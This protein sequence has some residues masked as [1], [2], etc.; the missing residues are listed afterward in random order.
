MVISIWNYERCKIESLKYSTRYE[1]QTNSRTAY[2]N[3]LKNKWLDKICKHMVNGHMQYSFEFCKK[4]V[5]KYKTRKELEMK[6]KGCYQAC[7]R[8]NWLDEIA[9]HMPKQLDYSFIDC[10]K[11][12][13]KYK[14]RRE[15]QNN[16]GSHYKKAARK[17]WLNKICKHM[18]V[19]ANQVRREKILQ[20][21]IYKELYKAYSQYKITT[22]YKIYL[23]EKGKKKLLGSLDFYIINPKNK[24]F[25][26]FELKHS[27]STW[28]KNKIKKQLNK[29]EEHFKDDKLYKG[30]FLISDNGKYGHQYKHIHNIIKKHL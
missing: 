21:K 11:E 9:I 25:I 18:P 27:E 3:A 7:L 2:R 6:N 10:Q 23:N 17:N 13:I 20:N 12:S 28:T 4:E 29:Y 24:H 15:F 8:N 26:V 5:L 19:F 1:F 14:T 30:L 16:A 22:E